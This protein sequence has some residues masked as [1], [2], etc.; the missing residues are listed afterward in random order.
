MFLKTPTNSC[1]PTSAKTQIKNIVRMSTSHNIFMEA[2]RVF[3]I[4]F[5][6]GERKWVPRL[7]DREKKSNE[8]IT[9]MHS[10]ISTYYSLT[11]GALNS[12]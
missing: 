8:Q 10:A 7:L 9:F 12:Q 4:I 1:M 3:T 6:P 2:N 5:K 11:N